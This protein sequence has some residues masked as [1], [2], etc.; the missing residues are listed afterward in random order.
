[1]EYKNWIFYHC[2]YKRYTKRRTNLWILLLH[3]KIWKLFIYN[4]GKKN[5]LFCLSHKASFLVVSHFRFYVMITIPSH[6]VIVCV[7]VIYSRKK[8]NDR[9]RDKTVRLM[10]KHRAEK[11]A[12]TFEIV[13][14]IRAHIIFLAPICRA[15]FLSS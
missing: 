13:Y 2:F 12:Q 7:R 11:V 4:F 9:K 1:M 14:R 3:W 5:K 6:V 8:S 15:I 10:S